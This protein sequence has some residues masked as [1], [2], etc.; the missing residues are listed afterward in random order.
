[1]TK[2]ARYT[3]MIDYKNS[4]PVSQEELPKAMSAFLGT[5]GAIFEEGATSR[6]EAILPD[7]NRMMGWNPDYKLQGEDWNEIRN[8]KL[9]EDAKNLLSDTKKAISDSMSPKALN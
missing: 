2:L 9:C 6:I 5:T 4:I 3:V 7:Y 8:S 1:M